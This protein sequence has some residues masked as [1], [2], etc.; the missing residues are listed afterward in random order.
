MLFLLWHQGGA[1]T[2][3]LMART[4]PF[5]VLSHAIRRKVV[6]WASVRCS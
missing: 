3:H 1:K 6:G 2:D 4:S 5:L